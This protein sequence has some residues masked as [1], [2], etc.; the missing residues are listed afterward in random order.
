MSNIEIGWMDEFVHAY[1]Y[2]STAESSGDK[3][4]TLSFPS[5][6]VYYFALF[7]GGYLMSPHYYLLVQPELSH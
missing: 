3:V 4:T 1:L 7:L 2:V 5:Q 6:T